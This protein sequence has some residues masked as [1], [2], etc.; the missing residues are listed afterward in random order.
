[1]PCSQRAML[2]PVPEEY[3]LQRPSRT[4]PTSRPVETQWTIENQ[5]EQAPRSFH[6]WPAHRKVRGELTLKGSVDLRNGLRAV[7]SVSHGV[8]T[9]HIDKPAPRDPSGAKAKATGST[10]VVVEVPAAELAVGL[11]RGHIDMF[12]IAT[13]HENRMY[14]EICCFADNQVKRNKWIAVFRRMG[15]A[16][17]DVSDVN[18]PAVRL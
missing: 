1:M 9:L 4:T 6:Q 17:F 18:A 13:L 8:L 14:D 15:V 12:I 10:A 2:S 16:I 3:P 11:K 7:C 5:N